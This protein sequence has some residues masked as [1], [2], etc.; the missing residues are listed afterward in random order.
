MSGC[1]GHVSVVGVQANSCAAVAEAIAQVWASLFTPEAVQTRAAAGVGASAD[2]HMAVV[3]QEMAPAAVSF[4]LHTGA[5][6]VGA[7]EPRRLPDPR[8]EV[9]LA[10]SP[11]ALARVGSGSRGD[12]WRVEVD[13]A[14]GDATTTAFGG[15]ACPRVQ[16]HSA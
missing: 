5:D 1:G 7:A 6:R 12:P 10:G 3:V 2:A 9:E 16:P 14:T 4:V 8:L 15:I 11:E 13:L